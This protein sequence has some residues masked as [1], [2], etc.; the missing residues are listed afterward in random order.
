MDKTFIICDW[1]G[2]NCRAALSRPD[3]MGEYHYYKCADFPNAFSLMWQMRD[4]LKE[5]DVRLAGFV[6]AIAGPAYNKENFIFPNNKTY[7]EIDF[8][9]IKTELGISIHLL[10]DFAAQA[11]AL[12]VL[13]ESEVTPIRHLQTRRALP[14]NIF[15]ESQA[16]TSVQTLPEHRYLVIG[17]GTGLGIATAFVK[18]GQALIADGEGSHINFSPC[19]EEEDKILFALRARQSGGLVSCEGIASG[20]GLAAL[21]HI[22]SG[23]RDIKPE[24]VTDLAQKGDEHALTAIHFFT[25]AL[26]RLAGSV[27]LINQVTGGVFIPAGSIVSA[28]GNQSHSNLF[29]TEMERNDYLNSHDNAL[30]NPVKNLPV[31]LITR[32]ETGLLGAHI[33]AQK[34]V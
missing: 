28:L 3:G 25:V 17:P 23:G 14:R 22:L 6:I 21:Y 16:R 32:E 8:N 24:M 19:N 2:T 12:L 5:D 15:F 18:G 20:R 33:F 34:F 7:G 29:I 27:C 9:A 13:K 4:D 1:G 30:H 11:Y 26:G 31:Y 10:N